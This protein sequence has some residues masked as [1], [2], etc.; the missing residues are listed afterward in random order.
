MSTRIVFKK[1]MSYFLRG[2]LPRC[3]MIVNLSSVKDKEEYESL[4]TTYLKFFNKIFLYEKNIYNGRSRIVKT[5]T[6]LD[7]TTIKSP[8][9]PRIKKCKKKRIVGNVFVKEDENYFYMQVMHFK[10][11]AII[12]LDIEDKEKIKNLL[13]NSYYFRAKY[14][15]SYHRVYFIHN[16]YK[17]RTNSLYKY[18]LG[19]RIYNRIVHIDGNMFNYSK[20]NLKILDTYSPNSREKTQVKFEGILNNKP[21]DSLVG[22]KRYSDRPG[23]NYLSVITIKGREIKLGRFVDA[24]EAA[25]AYDIAQIYYNGPT[26]TK[27]YPYEYYINLKQDVVSK[28]TLNLKNR[29]EKRKIR[30]A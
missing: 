12:K 30:L 19:D 25:M 10:K 21:I 11:R 1:E 6:N 22:V 8:K 20:S 17:L 24:Y 16:K 28:W 15:K 23:F 27:N 29:E 9:I 2:V 4:T 5:K 14:F 3:N 18:I 7:I 13:K 26:Y